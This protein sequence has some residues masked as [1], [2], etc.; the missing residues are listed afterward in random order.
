M[1]NPFGRESSPEVEDRRSE[2]EEEREEPRRVLK[3]RFLVQMVDFYL[4]FFFFL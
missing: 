2:S 4:M 1:P 3:V